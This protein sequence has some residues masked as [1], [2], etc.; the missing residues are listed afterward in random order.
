MEFQ[1]QLR[2]AWIIH[3]RRHPSKGLAVDIRRSRGEP[4]PVQHIEHFK[5]ELKAD[6]LAEVYPLGEGEI[7]VQPPGRSGLRVVA[8]RI[9][10]AVRRLNS[11]E[12]CRLKIA[13]APFPIRIAVRRNPTVKGMRLKF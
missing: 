4:R 5:S 7:L 10:Q 6:S 3:R 13:V 1:P 12:G 2:P 11:E 9:A 8:R